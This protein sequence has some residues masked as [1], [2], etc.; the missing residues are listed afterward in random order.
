M[1]I[2]TPLFCKIHDFY[3]TFAS[4]VKTEAFSQAFEPYSNLN[5]LRLE[6]KNGDA[7]ASFTM[8]A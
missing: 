1:D 6:P 4:K 3:Q 8:L 5:C 2:I 7:N